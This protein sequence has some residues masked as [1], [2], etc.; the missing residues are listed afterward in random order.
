MKNLT[1]LIFIF[2][3]Y[4]NNVMASSAYFECGF[5]G[6]ATQKAKFVIENDSFGGVIVLDQEHFSYLAGRTG[7]K[8]DLIVNQEGTQFAFEMS[9][10]SFDAPTVTAI[11]LKQ[12]NKINYYYLKMFLVH[13]GEISLSFGQCIR[14]M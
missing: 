14:L 4:S 10:T 9:S 5:L 8:V 2:T 1:L 7:D 13:Q 3:I 11:L 12:E 6:G